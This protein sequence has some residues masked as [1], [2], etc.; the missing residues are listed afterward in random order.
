MNAIF[1]MQIYYKKINKTKLDSN[2]Y[3]QIETRFCLVFNTVLRR[4]VLHVLQVALIY[5]LLH[6]TCVIVTINLIVIYL[7]YYVL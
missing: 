7:L 1:G 3:S 6:F 2:C 5:V 4:N